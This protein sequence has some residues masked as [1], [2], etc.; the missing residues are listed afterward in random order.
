MGLSNTHIK[1]VCV[2]VCSN[3]WKTVKYPI[4]VWIVIDFAHM[5]LRNAEIPCNFEDLAIFHFDFVVFFGNRTSTKLV[6][7]MNECKL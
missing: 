5:P 1:I 2:C 6:V 4:S 3:K 7:P